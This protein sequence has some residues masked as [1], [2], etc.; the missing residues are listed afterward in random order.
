MKYRWKL[1]L[2]MLAISIGPIVILRTFGIRN[3]RMMAGALSQEVQTNRL[4]A[5]EDDLHSLLESVNQAVHMVRERITLALLPLGEFMRQ[6]HARGPEAGPPSKVPSEV[7]LPPAGGV[8]A[9][10]R[11]CLTAPD[12]TSTPYLRQARQLAPIERTLSAVADNLGDMLLRQ[13]VALASGVAAAYTCRQPG[14]RFQDITGEPW[15]RNAFAESVYS[16]SRPYREGESGRWVT[17]VSLLLED[18]YDRPFGVVSVVVA[19]DRLLEQTLRFDELP[20]GARTLIVMLDRKPDGRDIGLR[21]LLELP[22]FPRPAAQWLE[23]P[24]SGACPKVRRDI[25]RRT[26]RALRMTLDGRD[27]YLAYAPLPCQGAA[28]LSIIPAGELLQTVEP[29][30]AAIKARLR[31]VEILT[32]GFLI[33]LAAVNVAVVFIF[34]GTVTKPLE[35]LSKA[36]RR[37]AGGDF[38]A[39]VEIASRDEFGSM[40]AV[41][42]SV[43]PQLKEHYRVREALQAAVEIQQSLLPLSPPVVPG[44]DIHALSLYSEQVG[45]DYHDYLCVGEGGRQRLCVVVGDVSG[46]GIPSAITMATARAFLRLRASQP[47]TLGEIVVDV[48]RKFVEDVEYS[49]QFMTLFIARLDGAI[50]RIEWVRAGHEPALLYDPREDRFRELAGPGAPLGVSE[51]TR[52][53]ESTTDMAV[54]QVLV[55]GTD[56]LWETQDGGGEMFGKKRLMQMVRQNATLPARAIAI[57]LVDGVEE[58]RG[59]DQPADDITVMVVKITENGMDHVAAAADPAAANNRSRAES[60]GPAGRGGKSHGNL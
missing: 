20:P 23:L 28:W 51:S 53:A 13:H 12:S 54:G 26:S 44:L 4:A 18:E 58:F 60:S 24:E 33:L 22:A 29:V 38:N 47:G 9:L 55:I 35:A 19:L 30:Q 7:L 27:V 50:G 46:H 25:A 56:G 59:S 57:A 1:L 49:G 11:L 41:F 52:F 31:R 14:L 16:W 37:L 32:A 48:N 3:V 40:G 45:G 8:Q 15:Y 10:S 21:V 2:L 43:G 34:S 5:A 36:A 17:A 39:R 42:N 6:V